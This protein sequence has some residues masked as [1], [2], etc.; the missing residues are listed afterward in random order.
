MK[1]IKRF[2]SSENKNLSNHNYSQGIVH[3]RAIRGLI[4]TTTLLL[5]QTGCSWQE[6]SEKIRSTFTSNP[7]RKL[8]KEIVTLEELE[9]ADEIIIPPKKI[10]GKIVTLEEISMKHLDEFHK[11]FSKKVRRLVEYPQKVTI[12][13]DRALIKHDVEAVQKGKMINYVIFDNKDKKLIGAIEIKDKNPEDPGQLSDWINENYWG[14]GR[15]RESLKIISLVFFKYKKNEKEFDAHVRLWNKRSY[16][17][18]K[19]AGMEDSGPIYENGRETKRH[20]IMKR[21]TIR[22]KKEE[23]KDE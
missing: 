21:E 3:N 20:M 4:L 1:T 9:E 6:L 22:Q 15:F 8:S 11:A 7:T 5:L 2:Y 10:V 23:K 17:A 12:A 18:H 16:L 14:G 13:F 19:N